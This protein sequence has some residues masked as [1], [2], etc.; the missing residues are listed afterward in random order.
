MPVRRVDGDDVDLCGDERGDALHRICRPADRRACEQ[1][2]VLVASGIRV[3]D[4][5]L[6]ILDRDE[7]LQIAVF[8]HDGKFFD[9]VLAE[10]FLRLFQRRADGR[11]DEVFLRHDVI[12]RLI[13]VG[14]EAEIAVGQ[15]AD[16]LAVFCDGHAADLVPLHERD[17]LAH[18]VVGRE[19][20]RVGDDAVFAAL[21]LVHL[22]RLLLD[23]HIFM[24]DA[25]AAFAGDSDRELAL[26]DG[27]H[28]RAHQRYIQTNVVRQPR[29]QIDLGGKHVGCCR[30]QK[31][32]V[33]SQTLLH[34]L[35]HK[36]FSFIFY[37][38]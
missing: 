15:N 18:A 10:D 11:R 37:S 8:I 13:V 26:G 20:K 19:E 31:H 6:Y 16:E 29:G 14:F 33:K 1:A 35:V 38:M 22:A 12:D 28:R 4:A 25:D 23:G 30:D 34:Y 17:R 24:D 9:A 27:V 2:A 5:L 7:S 36:H 3:L 21:D 32:V